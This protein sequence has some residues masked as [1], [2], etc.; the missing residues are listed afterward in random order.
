MSAE[1]MASVNCF[2]EAARTD[3]HRSAFWSPAAA[4]IIMRFHF[5]LNICP[6]PRLQQGKPKLIDVDKVLTRQNSKSL[7]WN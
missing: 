4:V 1:T 5:E 7:S 3:C 6:R 2:L